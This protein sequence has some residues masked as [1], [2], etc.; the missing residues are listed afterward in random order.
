[1]VVEPYLPGWW[2][3]YRLSEKKVLGISTGAVEGRTPALP[4]WLS[5]MPEMV[6]YWDCL[7]SS[8]HCSWVYLAPKS[9][10]GWKSFKLSHRSLC[11]PLECRT[12]WL[13]NSSPHQPYVQGLFLLLLFSDGQPLTAQEQKEHYTWRHKTSC[14]VI[15]N[16]VLTSINHH[17]QFVK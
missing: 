14:N 8:P 3:A 5:A 4:A 17:I 9:G 15:W 1:M 7:I 11:V 2:D 16:I 10:R 13:Q 6:L 12:K